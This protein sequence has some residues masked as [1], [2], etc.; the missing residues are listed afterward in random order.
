[1]KKIKNIAIFCGSSVGSNAEY[2]HE[3]KE[4]VKEIHK[5]DASI[6]YGGGCTGIM[7]VVAD[8]SIRLGVNI[9]GV[10]PSF[11]MSGNVVHKNLNELILT[12][13]MSERKNI[14]FE[15]ADACIVLPGGFGTFD[16]LFEALTYVQLGL[17][18]MPIGLLNAGGYYDVL[19]KMLDVAVDEK[20]VKKEHLKAVVSSNK[21]SEL[22]DLM[23]NSEYKAPENWIEKLV[24]KNSF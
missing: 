6:I 24:Q 12:K 4:L 3:T 14:I 9:I 20:F 23:Q 1:M 17:K 15:K 5:I 7:G 2:A 16:E 19:I 11:F 22:I 8:E 21:A 13:T 10:V 18:E